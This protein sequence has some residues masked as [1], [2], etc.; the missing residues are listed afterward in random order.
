MSPDSLQA[1]VATAFSSRGV[2]TARVEVRPYPTEITVLAFVSEGMYARALDVAEEVEGQFAEVSPDVLVVVR[3]D[4]LARALIEPGQD[5]SIH[6]PLAAEFIRLIAA[7]N[8]VSEVQPS[9]SYVKDLAANVATATAQRHHLIF[10]RRGAGKSTLLV[11]AKQ[12]LELNDSLT[13]WV[14]LQTFQRDEP[15]LIFLRVAR[16][17]IG[18]LI[19]RLNRDQIESRATGDAVLLYEQLGK[20]VSSRKTSP[21]DA[22]RLIPDVNDIL[23]RNLAMLSVDLFVFV[24]DF[25]YVP[26]ASQPDLLDILHACVRDCRAWL[27]VASIRHLTRWF[28][29]SPPKGLQTGHDADVIDLDITLQEPARVRAFLIEVMEQ[30]ALEVGLPSLSRLFRSEALDRLVLASGGVPRDFLVLGAAGVAHA[31]NRENARF[32][33]VQEVNQVAGQRAAVKI[34]ELEED[35]AAN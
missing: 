13:A 10:G 34:Q 14:N 6:G 7:R 15:H 4:Q 35:I 9:L 16:E 18:V 2:R 31:R 29:P 11:E 17:M 22:E 24:D 33:G 5:R 12:R 8:R 30:Y 19:T 20:L 3:K 1:E 28:T 21:A 27:K 25:Y 32:V 23:K 26:R